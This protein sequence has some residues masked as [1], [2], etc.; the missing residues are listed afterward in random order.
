MVVI[1]WNVGTRVTCCTMY[2]LEAYMFCDLDCQ[3]MVK[4]S[5]PRLPLRTF[6]AYIWKQSQFCASKIVM[7]VCVLI[8]LIHFLFYSDR[9]T[10]TTTFVPIQHYCVP[11]AL[12]SNCHRSFV[13]TYCSYLVSQLLQVATFTTVCLF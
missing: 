4:I 3:I 6:Q 2:E 12:S 10:T 9:A 7:Y 5:S 1:N 8:I 13:V 11:V